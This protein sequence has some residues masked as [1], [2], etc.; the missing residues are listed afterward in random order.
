[1]LWA[2][3]M[4]LK[5]NVA[6]VIELTPRAARVAAVILAARGRTTLLARGPCTA[7][8]ALTPVASSVADTFKQ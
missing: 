8:S 5:V 2:P 4:F 1:M 7:D 6:P 3:G